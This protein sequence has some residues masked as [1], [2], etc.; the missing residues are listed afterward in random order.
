MKRSEDNVVLMRSKKFA[1]G[2]IRLYDYLCEEKHEYVLSKQLLRSG[3][4]IGCQYQRSLK[5]TEQSRFRFK[6]EYCT[7]RGK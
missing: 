5:R 6:N 1:L 7:K 3:T 2:V 4:S